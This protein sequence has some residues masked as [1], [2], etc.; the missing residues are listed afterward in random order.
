M[1]ERVSIKSPVCACEYGLVAFPLQISPARCRLRSLDN[2]ELLVNQRL[3]I[4]GCV[5]SLISQRDIRGRQKHNGDPTSFC[6]ISV[7]PTCPGAGGDERVSGFIT[8][9]S[10]QGAFPQQAKPALYHP[11]SLPLAAIRRRKVSSGDEVTKSTCLA[12]AEPPKKRSS[13]P[14]LPVGCSQTLCPQR[15]RPS[16]TRAPVNTGSPCDYTRLGTGREENQPALLF[17]QVWITE[18]VLPPN[19]LLPSYSSRSAASLLSLT[20]G[21]SDF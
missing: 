6:F 18:P 21:D 8:R 5:C 9:R 20:P 4:P 15:G 1:T 12:V 7:N 3:H 17:Q 2:P 11:R 10:P 13:P 19:L 14:P 16:Q